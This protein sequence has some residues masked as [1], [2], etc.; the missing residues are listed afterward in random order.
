MNKVREK[1]IVTEIHRYATEIHNSAQR[2]LIVEEEVIR[3]SKQKRNP[4]ASDKKYE[5]EPTLKQ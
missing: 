2:P 3:K 1:K 4:V 5:T